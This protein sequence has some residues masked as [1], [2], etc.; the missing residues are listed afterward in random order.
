[1]NRKHKGRGLLQFIP[2]FCSVD[3]ETTGLSPE[4]DNIIEIGAIRYRGGVPVCKFQSLVKPPPGSDGNYVS[5]YIASFTH[6]SNEMLETA[7]DI[8]VVL[9]KFDKFLG[10]DIIVGYN[11]NFDINFLYDNYL[12]ILNRPLSNDYVDVLR[13][14]RKYLPELEHHTLTDTITHFGITNFHAHRAV[15]DC[16]V[17]GQVYLKFKEIVM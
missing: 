16:Y 1:M 7:P 13:Y 12:K 5:R 4:K 2:D 15:H 17:T 11:V 10:S 3:I 9:P 14:S 6:I 8:T